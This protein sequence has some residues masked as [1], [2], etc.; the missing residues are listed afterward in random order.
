[1]NFSLRSF[2]FIETKT[3]QTLQTLG[4]IIRVNVWKDLKNACLIIFPFPL[5]FPALG[6][7]TLHESVSFPALGEPW[8]VPGNAQLAF[9]W[10]K[11]KKIVSGKICVILELKSNSRQPDLQLEGY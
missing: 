2:D 7:N 6:T 10:L 3:S 11:K 9:L 1:M 8:N 4:I 5:E